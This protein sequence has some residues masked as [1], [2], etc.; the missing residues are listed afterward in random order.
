MSILRAHTYLPG[1]HD[2]CNACGLPKHNRHH[3]ADP[4]AEAVSYDAMAAANIH[5]RAGDDWDRDV[6][7]RAI[8]AVAERGEPFSL[9]EVRPLLP[10]VRTA[11]VGVCVNQLAK[12]GYLIDTGRR[13]MSSD[14]TTRHEIRIWVRA[15]TSRPSTV[16][17]GQ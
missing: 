12:A 2:T 11:L 14:P 10:A 13:V 3:R 1:E 6:I 5:P 9:N 7:T 16:E 4:A 8:R 15:E 17:G